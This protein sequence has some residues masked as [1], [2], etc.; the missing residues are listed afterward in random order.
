MYFE[1]DN[2][3]TFSSIKSDESR[4]IKGSKTMGTNTEP[5]EFL[6]ETAGDLRSCGLILQRKACQKMGTDTNIAFLGTSIATKVKIF[7]HLIDNVLKLL[8][9]H[10]TEQYPTYFPCLT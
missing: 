7:R 6:G 5:E 1:L 3:F 8:E 2:P 4:T 10:L 9:Q